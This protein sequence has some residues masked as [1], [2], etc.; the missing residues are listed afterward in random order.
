MS[1]NL[2]I[3]PKPIK[4]IVEETAPSFSEADKEL[5]G[6]FLDFLKNQ[7]FID[8]WAIATGTIV[9]RPDLRI[10]DIYTSDTD[11][12]WSDE[13]GHKNLYLRHGELFNHLGKIK[14]HPAIFWEM[15]NKALDSEDALKAVINSKEQLAIVPET[16]VIVQ[17][18]LIR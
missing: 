17:F 1:Q 8:R 13:E 4:Q 11:Q 2:E 6:G 3:A 15:N 14:Q 12:L 18:G 9:V 16:L 7:P 10:V 5:Y